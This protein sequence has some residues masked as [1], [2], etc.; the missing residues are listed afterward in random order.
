MRYTLKTIALIGTL[1]ATGGA[2]AATEAAGANPTTPMNEQNLS[3]DNPAKKA[4]A[5]THKK[6]HHKKTARKAT[7]TPSEQGETQRP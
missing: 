6:H 3:Q 7:K 4:P 2:F 1:L 5:K